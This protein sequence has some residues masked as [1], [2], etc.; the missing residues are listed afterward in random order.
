MNAAKTPAQR[1]AALSARRKA[2]GLKRLGGIWATPVEAVK[3]RAFVGE[4]AKQRGKGK[5]NA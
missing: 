2:M 3:I 4:L 1:Q 5:T